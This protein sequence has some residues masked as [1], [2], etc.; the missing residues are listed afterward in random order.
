MAYSIPHRRALSG[1]EIA[2]L[3]FLLDREAQNRVAELEALTVVARCGCGKCPTI[4]LGDAA[5][6]EPVT[7]GPKTEVASYRGRNA[8]G[9]TVGVVLIDRNGKLTELEAWS[10]EGNDISSWPPVA[11]LERFPWK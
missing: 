6:A 1:E 2:L 10:P 7:S 11:A 8:E 3:R 5:S 9:V 4:L